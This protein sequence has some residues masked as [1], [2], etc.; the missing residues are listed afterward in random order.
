MRL[1]CHSVSPAWGLF[2]IHVLPSWIACLHGGE[3]TFTE[4]HWLSEKLS[5][6]IEARH[7]LEPLDVN[8]MKKREL[9]SIISENSIIAKEYVPEISIS[10]IVEA[11]FHPKQLWM[12]AFTSHHKG[13]NRKARPQFYDWTVTIERQH[14][15]H[16]SMQLSWLLL[17]RTS[18]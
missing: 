15:Y 7:A 5:L 3:S 13:G 6:R 14:I 12:W 17:I 10:D 1:S 11:V 9:W 8:V 2:T 16:L 4:I 18:Q